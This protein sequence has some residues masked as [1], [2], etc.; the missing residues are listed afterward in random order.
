MK[1]PICKKSI[2]D[3]AL[4][5]PYCKARTGLICKHCNTVNSLFDLKCKNCGREILKLCQNCKSVNLPN[6]TKCRKCGYDFAHTDIPSDKKVKFEHNAKSVS[7]QSAKNILVKGLL[8]KNKKILS[9]S[10]EKGLGKSLVL[11]AVMQSLKDENISWL[12]GKCTPITQ[13][14]PGGLIQDILLNIFNLPNF[15]I[16]N[17]DFKKNASQYFKN[18]FPKISNNEIIDLLNF[19]YPVQE[20]KFENIVAAKNKTFEF[21][22]KIFDRITGINK[23]V[24]VIDNFDFID[25]FS[26]ELISR[27]L[28]KENIWNKLKLLLIYNETKPAKGYFYFPENEK[29]NFYL[30]VGISPLEFQQMKMLVEQKN[31]KF[32]GFPQL[33]KAELEEIYK[34]SG[35]NPSYINHIL[36]LCFDCQLC[37]QEFEVSTTFKGLLEHRLKIL[38]KLNPIAYT[39]LIGSSIIGDKINM[40]LVR[41]I[42]EIDETTFRDIL[43]YLKKMDYINHINDIYCEFSSLTLWETVLTTSKNSDKYEKINKKILEYFTGFTLNS[44]AI[45]GVI[46]QNLK[47]PRLALEIWTKNTK[48]AAYIGDL[49]LYAISQKQ[50]MALINELDE[51]ATLKIRYNISERL[52]KLLANSNP[53]EAIEYLPDAISNAQAVGDSPKEI[54]LLAYMSSCCRKTGNYFFR[55]I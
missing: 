24:F 28:K 8:S 18:E 26:Y 42:F 39:V 25:G 14:T 22:N 4:K 30:D 55:I 53:T 23:F 21:L 38:E 15:C 32:D 35:G 6:A 7:Q 49:N 34:I 29:E 37:G 17:L 36:S 44:N 31:K 11:K 33:N 47:Q 40:N 9:L 16:N 51:S 13:I 12:Y 45:L 10:G 5:C 46:A 2:P 54:E 48:L 19:L 50:S 20:G 43:I 1:C 3:N 52:G 27:Y 41:E